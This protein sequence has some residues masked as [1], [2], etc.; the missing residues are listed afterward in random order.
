MVPGEPALVL[1][2]DYDGGLWALPVSEDGHHAGAL[3]AI[4]ADADNE[5]AIAVPGGG[6]VAMCTGAG[7]LRLLTLDSA[8][9]LVGDML[10]QAGGCTW[11]ASPSLATNGD[12]LVVTW[13]GGPEGNAVWYDVDASSGAPVLR[14]LTRVSLGTAGFYPAVAWTG[15]EFLVL[16]ASGALSSFDDAGNLLGIRWHP[17]VVAAP[18]TVQALRMVVDSGVV[19]F[20]VMGLDSY[21]LGAGHINSFNYVE[22]SAS[23]LP[24][25]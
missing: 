16:D 18:G 25:R 21:L 4:G 24:S 7:D 6:A 13:D 12:T 20:A 8:G 15:A 22:I 14:E 2:N 19:T 17:G 23:P 11:S 9:A 10:A 3:Q 5:T 1:F